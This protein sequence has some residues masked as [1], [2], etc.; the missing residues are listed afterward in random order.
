MRWRIGYPSRCR[1]SAA[2][3]RPPASCSVSSGTCRRSAKVLTARV[4]VSKS[5]ISTVA[6]LTKFSPVA[7]PL[8]GGGQ[9]ASPVRTPN[10]SEATREI[11]IRTPVCDL[12]QIDHPIALGG[13]GSV[14][15][16]ELVTAVSGAGGLGA[17]GC[18]AARKSGDIDEAVLS[19]G[20][21]AG[22]IHDIAPAAE[23]ILTDRAARFI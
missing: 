6:A 11:M 15:V 18:Q 22:F 12:L 13:M 7:L 19:M 4:G 21:D 1:R 14:Y 16:P 9:R 20:Q 10:T 5:S 8:G 2:I 3:I 17:M 23:R